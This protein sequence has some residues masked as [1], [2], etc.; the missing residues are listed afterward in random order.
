MATGRQDW[1]ISA[2]VKGIYAGTVVPLGLTEDGYM[3]ALV[4]GNYGGVLKPVAVDADGLLLTN[5]TKQGLEYLKVRP[6]YGKSRTAGSNIYVTSGS[7]L[8]TLLTING[9]GAILSGSVYW[10][11]GGPLQ[12]SVELFLDGTGLGE[13]TPGFLYTDGAN[14]RSEWPS[15]IMVY[16]TVTPIY[17]IDFKFGLTFESQ[18]IIKAATT[19]GGSVPFSTVLSYALVPT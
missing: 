16:D 10:S 12:S 3:I 4:Q 19:A 18:L 7:G 9:Q 6:V 13:F 2:L 1:S 8:Q 11:I 15:R 5:I 14:D 17:R